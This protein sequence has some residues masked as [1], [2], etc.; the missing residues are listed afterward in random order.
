VLL[1]LEYW[2]TGAIR[3]ATDMRTLIARYDRVPMAC[4][5][6]P[7]SKN[8]GPGLK[9]QILICLATTAIAE[10]IFTAPRTV[11]RV[12]IAYVI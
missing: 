6:S 4:M 2:A 11:L 9:L 3:M 12:E 10:S 8:F 5:H 7:R 1:A